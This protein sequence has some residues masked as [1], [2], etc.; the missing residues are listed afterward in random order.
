[1]ESTP[2]SG[3]ETTA[4]LIPEPAPASRDG[5]WLRSRRAHTFALGALVGALGLSLVVVVSTIFAAAGNPPSPLPAAPAPVSEVR[6][7]PRAMPTTAPTPEPTVETTD[8]STDAA[9]EEEATTEPVVA[10]APAPTSSEAP[11]AEADEAPTSPG[12]SGSAPGQTKA[13]KKP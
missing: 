11:P 10:P 2:S 4:P 7:T 6:T 13:P 3:S 12:R 5:S 1:M 9:P 8:M